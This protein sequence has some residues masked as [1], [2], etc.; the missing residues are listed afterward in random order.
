MDKALE[1][2][3]S[4]D[5]V[6]VILIAINYIQYRERGRLLASALETAQYLGTVDRSLNHLVQI[7]Q[8]RTGLVQDGEKK[9]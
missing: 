4:Q 6:V 7:H 8:I 2:V 9:D 3:F 1:W 5:T